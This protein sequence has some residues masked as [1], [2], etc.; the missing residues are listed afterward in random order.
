MRFAVLEGLI[1]IMNGDILPQN[2]EPAGQW[3]VGG[4]RRVVPPDHWHMVG[5]IP[6]PPRDGVS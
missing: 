5:A 1:A 4:G 2:P 3:A 6:F